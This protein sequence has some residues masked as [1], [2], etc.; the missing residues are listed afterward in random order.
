MRYARW[1]A[2]LATVR[3][4]HVVRLHAT[5]PTGD[6]L[7][8]VLEF[9]EG[10]GLAGLLAGRG[11]LT[12]GEVVAVVAPLAVALADV[13]G[14]GV[15]HGNI[16]PANVLFDGS[17]KPLLS[18]LG[19]AA[20]IGKSGGSLAPAPGFADPA[21]SDGMSVARMSRRKR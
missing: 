16:T 8:L 13:H 19:V 14:R 18:D 4:E 11:R 12:A 5:V 10:G 17:G 1:A 2:L 7:V 15:L 3:H 20:L 21:T 9:A 6:G